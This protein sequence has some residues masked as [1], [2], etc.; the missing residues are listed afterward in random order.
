MMNPL[1]YVWEK[2]KE[3]ILAI[4]LW[5]RLGLMM[6]IALFVEGLKNELKKQILIQNS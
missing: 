6:R 2:E 4:A 5:T 1:R 3:R